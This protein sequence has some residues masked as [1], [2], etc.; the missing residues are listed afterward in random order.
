MDVRELDYKESGTPKNWCFWTVVLEKTLES[1]LDCKE[2][3]PVNPKR[4]HSWIFT[5]STDAKAETPVLWPPDGKNGLIEKDPDVG[6]NWRQEENVTTGAE[7]VGWHHWLDGHEFEQALGVGDG[8]QSLAYCSPWECK[9]LDTTEQLN[10]LYI[11]IYYMYVCV[12]LCACVCTHT[13]HFS[14]SIHLL[15]NA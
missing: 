8:Q 7:M 14:L 1:P 12:C 9:K 11:C 6:K 15:T 5:G 2:I 3:K 10:W 4:N 13:P